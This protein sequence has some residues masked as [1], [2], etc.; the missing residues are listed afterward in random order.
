MCLVI[1]PGCIPKVFDPMNREHTRF[2]PVWKWINNG[3]GRMIYGGTK[4]LK[5]LSHLS[6]YL[7]LIVELSR[8]GRLT[9]VSHR[10]VDQIGAEIEQKVNNP[11][12]DDEHLIAIVIVSRCMVICTDDLRAIPYIKRKDLYSDYHVKRPKIYCKPQ[13]STLCCNRHVID[14]HGL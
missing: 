14:P 9:I 1:D 7:P 6:K 8:R 12:L 3:K 5:E 10:K 2:I 4:Y 13:H 11:D